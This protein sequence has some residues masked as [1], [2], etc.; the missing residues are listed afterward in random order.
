MVI[1]CKPISSNRG[2]F[3]VWERNLRQ[4]R[5]VGEVLEEKKRQRS[6]EVGEAETG[7]NCTAHI[8]ILNF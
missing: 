7:R 1:V 4:E 8:N 6:R 3:G 2:K 5:E